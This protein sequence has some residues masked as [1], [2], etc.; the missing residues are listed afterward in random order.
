MLRVSPRIT[1]IG[2]G[3]ELS[4]TVVVTSAY[5]NYFAGGLLFDG[6]TTMEGVGGFTVEA[7]SVCQ[8]KTMAG[9]MEVKVQNGFN[10]ISI[11]S[12]VNGFNVIS[13][14]MEQ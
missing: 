9:L 1:G 12:T 11:T 6:A 7:N 13:N 5:A 4:V 3:S 10:G 8:S 2:N 14:S